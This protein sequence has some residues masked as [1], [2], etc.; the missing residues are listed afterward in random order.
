MIACAHHRRV[1]AIGRMFNLRH[2]QHYCRARLLETVRRPEAAVVEYR[3]ALECAPGSIRASHALGALYARREKYAEAEYWLAQAARCAPRRANIYFNLGYVRDKLGEPE[4]AL[5]AFGEAVRLDPK[6]DRAW[7]GMGLCHA[8][9]GR[10][11][12]AA[13][14]LE[15][16]ATLEAS[17]PV[18]WYQLG[19]AYHALGERGKLKEVIEHLFRF[20]PMM[21]RKLIRETNCGELAHLVRHLIE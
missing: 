11:D 10:H 17:N 12:A 5:E 9:M 3:L 16:A 19:M 4:R 6:L 14:A 21:T 20:N 18:V 15:E 7:Y 2:W 1:R 8:R 13:K